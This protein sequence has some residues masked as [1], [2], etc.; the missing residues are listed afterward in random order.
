MIL[1]QLFYF[2]LGRLFLFRVSIS[3]LDLILHTTDQFPGTLP[4]ELQVTAARIFGVI[5]GLSYQ[6]SV[7]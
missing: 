2:R 1:P 4:S 3:I 5:R 6:V 7:I